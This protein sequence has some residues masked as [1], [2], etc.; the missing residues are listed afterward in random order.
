MTTPFVTQENVIR[1]REIVLQTQWATISLIQRHLRLGYQ[2]AIQVVQCLQAEGLLI[3]K[4]RQLWL[5]A[6]AYHQH[7]FQHRLEFIESIVAFIVACKARMLQLTRPACS[8]AFYSFAPETDANSLCRKLCEKCFQQPRDFGDD[9]SA[10]IVK[11]LKNHGH[12]DEMSP[13]D[14]ELLEILICDK[15]YNH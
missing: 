6:D 12:C 5:V 15:F 13:S 8:E 9:P 10:A 14:I 11:F 3:P 1:A 7:T 4:Y 2:S